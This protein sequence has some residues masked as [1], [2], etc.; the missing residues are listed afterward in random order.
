MA[1]TQLAQKKQF[2]TRVTGAMDSL[3][4]LIESELQ[5]N[6]VSF[7]QYAR[8]CVVSAIVAINTLVDTNGMFWSELDMANVA[9]ILIN[10]ASLRLNAAANP[11]EVYFQLRKKSM[12]YKS[13]SGQKV[14]QW[15]K[16][17]EMGIEGD[18][19]DALLASFGRDVETVHPHWLVRENDGFTYPKFTGLD[20]AAPVW[21]PTG[22]GRVIRIVY[23]VS[24]KGGWIEFYIAERA[25][26]LPNLLAHVNN[27]LMNETFG[28][29]E[30]RFK[31]NAEQKRQIA[32]QK[33]EILKKVEQ[34]GLDAA[35]DDPALA[36]HISAAWREPHSREQMLIRKMR[37]NIVKKIPKDFGNAFVRECFDN[38]DENYRALRD[39]IAQHGNREAL[40]FPEDR[41]EA[42]ELVDVEASRADAAPEAEPEACEPELEQVT[43]PEPENQPF[44]TEAGPDKHNEQYDLGF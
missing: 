30:D 19:N 7:D 23:P 33:T 15:I 18:G 28:I 3:M 37:N 32:A 11:R 8:Q 10:I 1:D 24:R 26:V 5:G 43:L 39:E 35:L 4:P 44:A 16:T 13:E 25:D 9:S 42:V 2:H 38:M 17:V 20:M 29:C 22:S 36:T 6:L 40:D 41:Q 14:K 21:Q 34:L 27:N 12:T 31:A